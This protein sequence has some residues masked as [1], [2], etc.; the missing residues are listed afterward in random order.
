M[1]N[2]FR[3]IRIGRSALLVAAVGLI[4]RRSPGAAQAAAPP[5]P[6]R[7]PFA[8]P[9][10]PR[11][12]ERLRFVDIKHIKAELTLDAKKREVRGTVTHTVT[13]PAPVPQDGR[14]GL[15]QAHGL[16]A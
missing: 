3:R 13:P 9:G 2:P 15:R 1:S 11:K 7:R 14:A 5:A 8:K 12:P 4:G 16:K 10:T 6:P